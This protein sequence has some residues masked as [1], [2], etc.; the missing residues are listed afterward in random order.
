MIY[1]KQF[2]F[3]NKL[4]NRIKNN[5]FKY[6]TTDWQKWDRSISY[7]LIIHHFFVWI[8]T[9]F[10]FFQLSGKTPELI[11]LR[12]IIDKG[13]TRESSHNLTILIDISS[14]PW[15]LLMSRFLIILSI[16]LSSQVMEENLASVLKTTESGIWE[17]L[18]MGVHWEAKNLLKWLA[19]SS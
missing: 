10:D 11:H 2:I 14:K 3:F 15:A 5:S 16:S 1:I 8:G 19:F 13:L 7:L 9:M 17:S 6:F 18:S 4:K 12:N